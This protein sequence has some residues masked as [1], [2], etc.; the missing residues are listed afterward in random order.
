MQPLHRAD[1]ENI[2]D[3]DKRTVRSGEIRAL[4]ESWLAMEQERSS[5]MLIR[6][7]VAS[8]HRFPYLTLPVEII[9]A[10]DETGGVELEMNPAE[11]TKNS[12]P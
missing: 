10:L 3:R 9:N 12:V 7:W 1:V 11:R 8:N 5:L 6:N 2:R 4:A